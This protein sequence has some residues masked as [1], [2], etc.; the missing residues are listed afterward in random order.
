[1]F[2]EC[3]T[4]IIMAGGFYHGKLRRYLPGMCSEHVPGQGAS[5][6]CIVFEHK[7]EIQ[8]LAARHHMAS[9]ELDRCGWQAELL[10]SGEVQHPKHAK[11][12]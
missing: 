7:T 3:P 1:M 10:T 6:T 11:N 4:K 8:I 5:H 12:Q 2:D 9:V